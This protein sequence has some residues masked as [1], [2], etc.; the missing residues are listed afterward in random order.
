M[1][2]YAIFCIALDQKLR[3]LEDWTQEYTMYSNVYA[4][5]CPVYK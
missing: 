2:L 1:L 3:T 4:R 5:S